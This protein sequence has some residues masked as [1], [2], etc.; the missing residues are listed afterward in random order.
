MNEV[1]TH[2]QIDLLRAYNALDLIDA[3]VEQVNNTDVLSTYRQRL[4]ASI[5][6][7]DLRLGTTNKQPLKEET[8]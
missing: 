8:L 4:S 7:I 6:K 1:P 2:D 3:L 5:L